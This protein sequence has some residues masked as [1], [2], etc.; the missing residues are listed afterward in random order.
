MEIALMFTEQ[1]LDWARTVRFF[2]VIASREFNE[3]QCDLGN[4]LIIK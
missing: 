1:V 4:R 3:R 2:S